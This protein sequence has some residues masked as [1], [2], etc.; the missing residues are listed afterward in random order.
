M[1]Q[2]AGAEPIELT[3]ASHALGVS[4]PS[5]VAEVILKAAA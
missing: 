1:A 4:R 2:R 3:G 5:E